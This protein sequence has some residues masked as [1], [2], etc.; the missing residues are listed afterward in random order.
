MTSSVVAPRTRRDELAQIE[1][2]LGVLIRRVKRMLGARARV[3]H[4]ELAPLSFMVLQYVL[5]SGPVRAGELVDVFAMDKAGVSR[6]VQ[7]L[8]ELG[9]VERSPDP[10][11]RRACL[12]GATDDASQRIRAMRQQRSE[13][14]NRRLGD[15]TDDE[16]GEFAEFLARFNVALEDRE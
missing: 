14:F 16:L 10:D 13:R 1:S 7:H 6:L 15:W 2:E 8:V 4:P 11:D 9:L 3:V 12:L 5:D